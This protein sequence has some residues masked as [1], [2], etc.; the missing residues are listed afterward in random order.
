MMPSYRSSALVGG[1]LP[2]P[3]LGQVITHVTDCEVE[4]GNIQVFTSVRDVSNGIL[5]G[6]FPTQ[7]LGSGQFTTTI[8]TGQLTLS[9]TED[10][11]LAVESALG[12]VCAGVTAMGPGGATALCNAL[13]IAL[14]VVTV[15][16]GEAAFL[17]A[18]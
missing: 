13:A 14:D 15:P 3:T 8:P 4:A 1:P 12:V 5:V 2:E 16:S 18:G 9:K 10:V 17:V 6:R 7:Y 11:C